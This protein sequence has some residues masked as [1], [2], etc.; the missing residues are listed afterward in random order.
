MTIKSRLIAVVAFV[1]FTSAVRNRLASN[2]VR[3]R[4]HAAHNGGVR[5]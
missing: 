4:G 5:A 1:V 3:R 2:A